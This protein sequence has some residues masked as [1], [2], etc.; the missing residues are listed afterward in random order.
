MH[1]IYRNFIVIF[2]NLGFFGELLSSFEIGNSFSNELL[3]SLILNQL[4]TFSKLSSKLVCKIPCILG[5]FS[6]FKSKIKYCK[7]SILLLVRQVVKIL[8]KLFFSA[9][10]Y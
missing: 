8:F 4:L 5:V 10:K 6:I 1:F 2:H 9:L 7:T 3:I